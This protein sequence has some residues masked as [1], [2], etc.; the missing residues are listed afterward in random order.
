ML[1]WV[2]IDKKALQKNISALRQTVGRGV[3]LMPVIKANAYG[4][5][6]LEIA[7]LCA[8]NKQADRLCVVELDE[9]IALIQNK[10]IKKPILIL[11]ILD[12]D[13]KKISVAAK[14]NVAF[15]VFT[16]K[17]A[18]MLNQAGERANRQIKVH[19]KIDTGTARVGVLPQEIV[20]FVK[21]IKQFRRLTIEGIW[22]HFSSSESNSSVTKKQWRCFNEVN[23]KLRQTGIAAPFRHMACSAAAILYPEMR[24]DGVRAGLTVYG[25]YPARIL[26]KKISLLPVLSW[27]TKIIQMKILPKNTPIGYG[28]SYVTKRLTRLATIPV[29]YADGYDRRFGDNASVLVRGARC[30]IRGRVCMNL[31][32]VDVTG[33]KDAKAGDTVTLIGRQGR[34]EITADELAKQAHT[35]NY[36]IVTRIAHHIPRITV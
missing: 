19:I 13:V 8:R 24:A 2:E 28:G 10:I 7:R 33:V 11:D 9:A 18:E 27:R 36:E 29:G 21:K 32:M 15:P 1:T 20:D 31:A 12:L 14:H 25:L 34:A 6:F 26:K 22:S 5:G 35:I 16:L 17:Q 30:P 3:E 4:H 23:T